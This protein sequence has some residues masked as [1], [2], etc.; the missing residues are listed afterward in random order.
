MPA[1][2][3]IRVPN[4]RFVVFSP[5]NLLTYLMQRNVWDK[6]VPYR[7]QSS[8][9]RVRMEALTASTALI[10]VQLC[11]S[12]VM[13]GLFL[14]APAE[15][16]TRYW[17]AAGTL[18]AAGVL[19]TALNA[20]APRYAALVI[21]N[22]CIIFGLALQWAGIRL[23][24]KKQPNSF[25][26]VL[27][28]GFFVLFGL[29]LLNKA[30]LQARALA[31]T[32]WTFMFI[33]LTFYEVWTGQKGRRSFGNLIAVAGLSILTL[34]Y[35]ARLIGTFYQIP[36]F[37]PATATSLG[38]FAI[39]LGPM[40][41]AQ[42]L[43]SGLLLLYFEKIVTEKNH[44]ATHD[45]L[46]GILNRRALDAACEREIEVAKR[47]G[48]PFCVAFVDIDH[49]KHINDSHGHEVGDQ[50]LVDV[51]QVLRKH[52]RNIDLVGRN[53]GDEFCLILPGADP[54]CAQAI[55]ERLVG[56]VRNH[57][58]KGVE[59][60]S[61]SIG[62]AV[63]TAGG[64]GESLRELVRRADIELY[65]AKQQGRDRVCV[66]VGGATTSAPAAHLA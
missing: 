54:A 46:T 65:R 26:W 56:A 47:L 22:N 61:A 64:N 6:M 24:H 42:L 1:Y 50:V 59:P 52:C 32:V 2:R 49:F 43:F 14:A 31:A 53:G 55:G 23:F 51:A 15:K 62:M 58:V 40:A 19:I 34:C 17:A 44:L 13:T 5:R 3:W 39:F 66:S 10:I 30:P 63:W 18:V 41:G 4:A 38:V 7:N 11:V 57:R 12:L 25:G 27:A 28:A 20:G 29:L 21:G 45:G 35:A 37:L 33:L 9:H 48:N 16:C 60:F 36:S 8:P